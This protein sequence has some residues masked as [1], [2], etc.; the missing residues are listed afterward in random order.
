MSE[1]NKPY[2]KIK[3]APPK[4]KRSSFHDE[5]MWKHCNWGRSMPHSFENTFPVEPACVACRM[6]YRWVYLLAQSKLSSVE[7][8]RRSI[9]K[10]MQTNER[11]TDT[12]RGRKVESTTSA[13]KN[14]MTRQ[15]YIM[16]EVEIYS[17]VSS[18][19]RCSP[20]FTQL[21]PGHTTC[22]FLSHLNPLGNKINLPDHQ[23][24]WLSLTGWKTSSSQVSADL[25][26]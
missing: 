11:M 4:A 9:V 13:L 6:S 5:I 12:L 22:S 18:V 2:N 7:W 25:R 26:S 23:G 19:K 20:D 8:G 17:L 24:L 16:V 14:S 15:S 3:S 21:V 10:A 1:A